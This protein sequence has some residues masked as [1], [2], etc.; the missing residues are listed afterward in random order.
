MLHLTQTYEILTG[1]YYSGSLSWNKKRTEIDNCFKIYQLQEGEVF[2]CD[3]GQTYTLQKGKLYFINGNKLSHQ[4][5]QQAFSTHWLHFIPKDLMIHQGLLAL[6]TVTELPLMHLPMPNMEQLLSL[7]FS[8]RQDYALE[9]LRAQT[10]LQLI[11]LELFAT[12]PPDAQAYSV[13]TQRIEPAIQYI[14]KHYKESI[15][16]EQLSGL[17]CMSPNY[18]HK[19]FKSALNTTP[20]DYIALLRMNAALQ[21]L[22]DERLSIKNIAYELGFTDDAHFCRAFKKYYRITPGEYKKKRGEL[23]F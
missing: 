14:N 16:L 6:P 12:Y 23:L 3:E 17:C 4:Y 18:F 20:A 22:I 2:V 15:K 1:G 13:E 10:Y 5:C 8:S 9:A 11:T 21:L 7:D 19:I